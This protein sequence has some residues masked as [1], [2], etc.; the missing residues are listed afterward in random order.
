MKTSSLKGKKILIT[1][2]TGFVGFALKKKLSSLGAVVYGISRSVFNDKKNLRSNMLN[3]FA[4]NDFICTVKIQMCV[5][6][7][8]EALVESGQ[9][10]PYRTFKIN[11]EGT[12]NIL[13][14]A[15]KNGLEK[16]IIASTAHVYGNN[17]LPYLEKYTPKPS[18][19]YET[20]KACTDLIA[21]SYAESFHLPVL[22]PRFVNIYGP[23]D[24]NFSRLIPKTIQSV[25]HGN[26]PKMW[27][28]DVV[29]DYLFITDAVDAYVKL[30]SAD[31][32]TVEENRIFNFGTGN[33]ISVQELIKKIIFLSES[34]L[35]IVRISEERKEEIK[36][37]YVSFSKAKK[38]LGW[39]SNTQ[40]DTGLTNTIKWYKS[41]FK[42]T[43][44]QHSRL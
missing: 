39:D 21:Q 6:L 34:N 10:D 44:L 1:G 42:K 2:I 8:S 18:R 30:L 4:I 29:R 28:G 17:K 23:G 36:K 16:I 37:Q 14:S 27:G 25:L 43:S 24:L 41:Y 20:S 15:R 12:L 32:P 33:V 13:E 26:S 40:L 31:I 19:P 38:L 9:K 35:S 11:T 22:I 3:Y 7:A 5:H